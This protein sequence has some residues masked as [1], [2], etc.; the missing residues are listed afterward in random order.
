VTPST[1]WVEVGDEHIEARFGPWRAQT[2][3]ANVADASVTGPYTVPKTIGPAHLSFADRGLTFATT[4]RRG[5]CISFRDPVAGIDPLGVIRHPGLTV[6]VAD[7]EGLV[8]ALPI[9]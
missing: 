2:A 8:D 5:V 6:T 1:A 4:S 7:P 9:G 3:L